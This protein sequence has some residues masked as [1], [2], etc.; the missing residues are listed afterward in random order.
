MPQ[1]FFEGDEQKYCSLTFTMEG[2]GP[3]DGSILRFNATAAARKMN[4]TDAHRPQTDA[5]GRV[6]LHFPRSQLQKEASVR[7][8]VQHP[9]SEF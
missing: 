8:R 4:A 5:V 3:M 2:D 6:A 7:P 9:L 1:S